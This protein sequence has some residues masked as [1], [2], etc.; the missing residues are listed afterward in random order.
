MKRGK[1]NRTKYIPSSSENNTRSVLSAGYLPVE[2][3]NDLRRL[4][5]ET[6][7]VDDEGLSGAE[8]PTA[9]NPM[10]W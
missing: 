2:L 7:A 10:V 3:A 5:H 4:G 1:K 6:D 8:D 9:L